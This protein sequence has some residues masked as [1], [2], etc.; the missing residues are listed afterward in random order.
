MSSPHQRCHQK[1]NH[2]DNNQTDART[3]RLRAMALPPLRAKMARTFFHGGG[4]Q[5]HHNVY[6]AVLQPSGDPDGIRR[7][8]LS[9]KI[10]AASM[11]HDSSSQDFVCLPFYKLLSAFSFIWRRKISF[12]AFFFGRCLFNDTHIRSRIIAFIFWGKGRARLGWLGLALGAWNVLDG[13]N[14]IDAGNG[15]GR[16]TWKGCGN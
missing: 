3:R 14:N 5:Q 1:K 9:V 4:G 13:E 10:S 16:G 15:M 11:F 7:H 12:S 2:A 6:A 8:A